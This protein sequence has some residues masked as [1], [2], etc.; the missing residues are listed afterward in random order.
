MFGFQAG[1]DSCD[2]RQNETR[3]DG[4]RDFEGRL[5]EANLERSPAAL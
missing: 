1:Q 2:A 3:A 5:P 4:S